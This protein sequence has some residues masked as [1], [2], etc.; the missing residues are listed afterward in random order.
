MINIYVENKKESGGYNF[1]RDTF[2]LLRRRE[3]LNFIILQPMKD[4]E[5]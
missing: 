2:N 4:G 5:V 3:G 1:I